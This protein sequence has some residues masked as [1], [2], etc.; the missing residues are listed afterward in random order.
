MK[1]ET[2]TPPEYMRFYIEALD[3][4]CSAAEDEEHGQCC[5]IASLTGSSLFYHDWSDR[6]EYLV[7]LADF[8]VWVSDHYEESCDCG[9]RSIADQVAEHGPS[10]VFGPYVFELMDPDFRPLYPMPVCV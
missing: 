1:N 10:G 8:L 4:F 7:H 2:T 5:A 3:Q 9:Y 6:L